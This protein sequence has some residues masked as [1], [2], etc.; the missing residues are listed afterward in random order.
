MSVL[1]AMPFISF[2]KSLQVSISLLSTCFLLTV[3]GRRK[4]KPNH[5]VPIQKQN[6]E[7]KEVLFLKNDFIFFSQ[8]CLHDCVYVCDCGS[9]F[10]C[11]C[12][13]VPC[14]RLSE[15]GVRS[16]GNEFVGGCELLYMGAGN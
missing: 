15:E 14:L 9:V 3:P 7:I 11:V 1:T 13:L 10:V 12:R 4:T 16:S 2:W 8:S 5:A 6:T